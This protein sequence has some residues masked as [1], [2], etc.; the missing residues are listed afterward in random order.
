M[1]VAISQ[2]TLFPWMGYFDLIKKSDVFI[3]LDNVKFEKS[4]WQMR[5]RLKTITNGIEDEVWIRIP[6][7]NV[8]SNTLIKDVLID[9]SNNWKQKHVTTFENN[10]GKKFLGIEFLNIMYDRNWEKLVDFNI[11]FIEKCCEF[12]QIKTKL[13]SAS[14]LDVSGKKE[15]LVLN[16]CKKLSANGYLANLGSRE[17]LEGKKS[18]FESENIPIKYHN[19]KHPIY[20]QKGKYFI[21]KLSI[22]DLLFNEKQNARKFL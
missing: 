13:K 15:M 8:D 9:N 2:P 10:Y 4:S 18:M 6:T 22:L 20:K 7:S 1:I 17:Y 11:E 14:E 19:Y 5:N 16:I 3:F 21:E 12:L